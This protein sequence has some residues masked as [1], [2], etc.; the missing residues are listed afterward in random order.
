MMDGALC[1]GLPT[2]WWFPK[3][4]NEENYA[5]GRAVCDECAIAAECLER[6]LDE[7]D[8]MWGGFTPEERRLV[9][10]S[11][12]ELGSGLPLVI[13]AGAEGTG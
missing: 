13:G 8:G 4:E 11:R 10:W 12:R 1:V 5:R 9:A 2:I 3:R 6:G 7:P